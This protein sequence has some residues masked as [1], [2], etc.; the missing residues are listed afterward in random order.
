MQVSC[1]CVE[2]FSLTPIS[3]HDGQ[4]SSSLL[5]LQ[6]LLGSWYMS[7]LFH[8][9]DAEIYF[10]CHS[11]LT[12][13]ENEPHRG[14]WDYPKPPHFHETSIGF[15]YLASITSSV[16]CATLPLSQFTW[17]WVEAFITAL[18]TVIAL[19]CVE[20]CSVPHTC[21]RP[22]TY[23]EQGTCFLHHHPMLHG[24]WIYGKCLSSLR[25]DFLCHQ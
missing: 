15:L 4:E 11:Y 21:T 14:L 20:M 24:G 5:Y 13:E 16:L 9:N 6:K 25:I 23:W 17:R 3:A 10:T 12:L 8:N 18:S 1:L 19:S 2:I 22:W 7:S